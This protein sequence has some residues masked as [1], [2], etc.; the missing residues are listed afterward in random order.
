MANIREYIHKEMKREKMLNMLNANAQFFILL[1]NAI[2]LLEYYN[3][4]FL[5]FVNFIMFQTLYL[6]TT[7]CLINECT[8]EMLY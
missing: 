4:S 7:K 3:V 8:S 2:Y 6:K 1:H 5:I